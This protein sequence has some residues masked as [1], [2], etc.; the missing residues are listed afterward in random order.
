[1][2][3]HDLLIILIEK[4]YGKKIGTF[5]II[6]DFAESLEKEHQLFISVSTL[7][8]FFKT[9]KSTSQPSKKTLNALSNYLGF[10]S[11]SKF[12]E[13]SFSNSSIFSQQ[14]ISDIKV[15]E[16]INEN[17][18]RFILNDLPVDALA[19]FIESILLR[20]ILCNNRTFQQQILELVKD[21][22]DN[23][24]ISFLRENLALMVWQTLVMEEE[25]R[26]NQFIS[27][28]IKNRVFLNYVIF[29]YIDYDHLS[30]RYGDVLEE[31]DNEDIAP[32]QSLFITAILGL[33]NFLKG[34]EVFQ[35][36][37]DIPTCVPDILL[38]RLMA[39]P[40]I[41]LHSTNQNFVAKENRIFEDILQQGERQ[42][43]KNLFFIEVIHVL[44]IIKRIDLISL[45]FERFYEDLFEIS[46]GFTYLNRSIY[47]LANAY[48]NLAKKDF[49]SAKHSLSLVH[50]NL[51]KRG[52]LH[53]WFKLFYF[54]ASYHAH[55]EL[56]D[57]ES[58]LKEYLD[59]SQ[60]VGLPFFNF[61]FCVDYFRT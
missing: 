50:H 37:K 49:S 25:T 59:Y 13:H 58:Y 56:P 36:S 39:Y 24:R 1:M 7:R 18:R 51:V 38:G 57:K 54:I 61:A 32:D 47:L 8:R 42:D 55:E 52:S 60:R 53:C 40:L 30:S 26:F 31:I 5:S 9:V 46:D 45:I 33:R 12:V 29:S 6:N 14:T 22:V 17:Q 34:E 11:Y 48:I 10:E 15:A 20:S 28:H 27:N 44:I 35:L 19:I 21:L 4:K 43:K 23:K 3:A 41:I 2:D 16:Q